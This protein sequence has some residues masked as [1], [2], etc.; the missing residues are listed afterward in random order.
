MTSTTEQSTAPIVYFVY[1]PT[2]GLSVERYRHTR[3]IVTASQVAFTDQ[4]LSR[5]EQ[6]KAAQV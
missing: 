6:E 5:Q 4:G 3:S 1:E 2:I